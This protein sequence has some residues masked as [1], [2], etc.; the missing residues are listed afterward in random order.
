MCLFKAFGY[1]FLVP[2]N[3]PCSLEVVIHKALYFRAGCGSRPSG[4]SVLSG[5]NNWHH[6][7][8][9][10]LQSTHNLHLLLDGPVVNVIWRRGKSPKTRS[11]KPQ[12]NGSWVHAGGGRTHLFPPKYYKDEKASNIVLAS[13]PRRLWG[14]WPGHPLPILTKLTPSSKTRMEP[15]LFICHHCPVES[16][17]VL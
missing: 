6:W 4:R 15:T 10:E 8:H 11:P 12:M 2:G 7:P 9:W 1:S 17:G 5:Q 3:S 14:A 13:L 16:E